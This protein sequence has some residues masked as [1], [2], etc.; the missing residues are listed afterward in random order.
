MLEEKKPNKG[1]SDS[2]L[3]VLCMGRFK[4]AKTFTH[5]IQVDRE[6]AIKAYHC[7]P[8][9][10]EKEGESAFITSDVRDTIEWMLPQIVEMF[11]GDEPAVEFCAKNA[12]DVESAKLETEYVN[13]VYQMQNNGF[14]NT[15]SW[16][17]DGLLS[18]TGVVKSYWDERVDEIEEEYEGKDYAAFQ[19]LLA[20]TAVEIKEV[21]VYFDGDSEESEYSIEEAK[22]SGLP[23]EMGRFEIKCTRKED[24]S[25]V[26][27]QVIAPENFF[28][29][30]G[31]DSLD[32]KDALFACHRTVVTESD[33]L[34]DGY[35][36]KL[37]KSIPDGKD[38]DLDVE[39]Q[40]RFQDESVMAPHV[41]DSAAREITVY[42]FYI[43]AD[44]DGNGKN[45]LRMIKLAGTNGSVLLENEAVDSIPFSVWTPVINTHKFYGMSYADMVMDLQ[46]LRSTLMRQMLNNLYM[47]NHP[48][49][50]ILDGKVYKEDLLVTRPGALYRVKE[51]GAIENLVTPFVG[52]A[53]MPVL[54]MIEEMR[55]ERTGVSPASQG[56]DPSVLKDSTNLVGPMIMSQALQRLKMVARIF[57]ETGYKHLM[58]RI[59]E[60]C[61][62]HD[63]SRTFPMSGQ[64]VEVDPRQWTKRTQ[65]RVKVGVGHV[66]K[67]Q[68]ITA[69]QA[70]IANQKEIALTAGLD[71]PLTSA[72]AMYQAFVEQAKLLGY[73]DGAKF[74]RDPATYQPPEPQQSEAL[75]IT[76]ATT[77]ADVQKAAASN[78]LD[79]KKHDDEMALKK[80]QMD[81]QFELEAQRLEQ[82]KDLKREE[83]LLNYG[84]KAGSNV[85][86]ESPDPKQGR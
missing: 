15:Y 83:M 71:S 85:G 5:G 44:F 41:E 52:E 49:K 64:Y 4:D 47:V 45:E 60:L 25:Q 28:V 19:A 22:M 59:H 76:E 34:V 51:Q 13:H 31:H 39:K 29:E 73:T 3:S 54:S 27:V 6:N 30:Q 38:E 48:A 26:R 9:G 42:E 61:S 63:M 10:D 23:L 78:A 62:K 79:L 74:Y 11:C 36:V 84:T 65:Y 56:L 77:V 50:A 16:I 21:S 69:I 81:R 43:R 1:M 55:Q 17:K 20:D 35:D 32:L 8:Y 37:V 70:I 68:R 14:L 46:K 58:L 18:K 72:D 2:E 57:A 86:F 7:D 66:D 67:M 12:E 24:N 80:Y 75:Q 53:T 33:L 82:E 40:A